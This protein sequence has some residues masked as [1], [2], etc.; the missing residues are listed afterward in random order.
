MEA[1]FSY[2]ILDLIYMILQIDLIF[3]MKINEVFFKYLMN[4]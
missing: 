3:S 4:Y 2:A 1:N